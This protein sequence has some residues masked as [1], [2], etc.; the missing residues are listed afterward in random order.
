M[1][2]APIHRKIVIKKI[3]E[4]G[5]HQV[6]FLPKYSHDLKDIKHNFSVLKR[7]KMYATSNIALDEII[8]DYCVAECLMLKLNNYKCYYNY[9]LF[10]VPISCKYPDLN[11]YKNKAITRVR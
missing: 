3:V 7:A 4:D 10:F 11:F 6:I 5:N 8:C 2:N 9:F 1:D